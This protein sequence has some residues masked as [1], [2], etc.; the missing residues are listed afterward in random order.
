MISKNRISPLFLLLALVVAVSHSGCGGGS[1]TTTT[2]HVISVSV[3]LAVETVQVGATMQFFADVQG[4]PSN[5]GVNWTLTCAAA[6]CGAVSPT[7]TLSGM[8]ATYAAPPT[9]PANDLSVTL[10]ATS[11]SDS[12]KSAA[13]TITVPSV[14]VNITPT[15]AS[16]TSGGKQQFTTTVIGDSSNG[17]VTWSLTG[18]YAC[19]KCNPP[20]G[21]TIDCSTGAC[22]TFSSSSTGSVIQ[23]TYTAPA[24]SPIPPGENG[25]FTLAATS[26]K[27][28]LAS[29]SASIMLVPISVAVSPSSASVAVNA[30]Q[31][32]TATT[33]DG[34]S[35]GV[36][37][38]L[39]QNGATCSPGCGT[40]APASTAS[41]A[42]AT[43]APPATAP[44]LPFVMVTA[45]SVKDTTKSSSASVTLT[46]ATGGLA[47][48]A[49]SGS[50][51]LLKGQY[52]FL[53]PGYGPTPVIFAAGSFTADGTGKITSGEDDS[54]TWT[55]LSISPSGSS[56]AVGPDHRGCVVLTNANG[57]ELS[58]LFVLGSINSSNGIATNGHIID[59]D[60]TGSGKRGT[61]S[62][63]LQDATS[64]TASQFKGNYAFGMAG[65]GA[66]AGTFNSDGIS[67]LAFNTIDAEF[68]G[69]VTSN[70]ASTP[71]GNFTCCSAN[72]RGTLTLNSSMGLGTFAMYMI[73][74]GDVFLGEDIVD[75]EAIGI[76]SGTTFA[77]ASLSG[78]SVLRQ[79]AQSSNG[80][81]VDIA[82]ASADGK[83]T[84]TVNDSVNNAGTF[85]ASSRALNYDVA[86]NGRVA[87][88]GGSTP[89]VLY[90]YGPNQGF[91]V[92]TDANMTF[93]ILEPQTAGPFSNASFSGQYTFGTENPSA[94]TVTMESGAVTAD[95]KGNAA[96]TSD[97]SSPT[98]LPQNQS[99]NFTYSFAADGTGNVGS[100][101]TAILISGN[102]LVFIS[103]TST[104]PTITVAE[105]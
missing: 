94:S 30:T 85:T 59:F 38:T 99:L 83:G 43:Y 47:C 46:T 21:K 86:S 92:G 91:L 22:G 1:A 95:G 14:A 2:A 87:L 20:G 64:F 69:T 3:G 48:S 45:T 80:P 84:I 66:I 82:V 16:V 75:G 89:P 4:D 62:I 50:E 81:V 11:A 67:A 28:T 71:G 73:N 70:L 58:F 9:P 17:G 18:G 23:L 12:T 105:K 49:G 79:T 98:G 40:I 37:W 51:S 44:A 24:T 96:G 55:D 36:T 78:A 8:P 7:S 60:A 26:A 32:F 39:T 77:Q 53:R 72:G 13:S 29:T 65:G 56:Y 31:Q 100:D 33:N 19:P 54:P 35:S 10:T 76:P 52:A 41:G 6:S 101:T 34:T 27:N 25:G 102:K 57:T 61:G 74:S 88:S 42:A 90:L 63:R 68:A 104:N 15:T 5:A 93:G 97:Q 103:N